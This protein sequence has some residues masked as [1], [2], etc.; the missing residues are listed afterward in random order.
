MDEPHEINDEITAEDCATFRQLLLDKKIFKNLLIECGCPSEDADIEIKKAE[1]LVSIWDLK[2]ETES[3]IDDMRKKFKAELGH[4]NA[5]IKSIFDNNKQLAEKLDTIEN[6]V[7]NSE[8]IFTMI[9]GS[10]RG[11]L[12]RKFF[13]LEKNFQAVCHENN[14]LKKD[15]QYEQQQNYILAMDLECKC[16]E[17]YML[18]NTLDSIISSPIHQEEY[19]SQSN[20]KNHKRKIDPSENIR[21]TEVDSAA[22]INYSPKIFKLDALPKSTKRGSVIEISLPK[23]DQIAKDKIHHSGSNLGVTQSNFSSKK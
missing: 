23:E 5:A 17:N 7:K 8:A 19:Q 2:Y 10:E 3:K 18:K 4:N 20:H 11:S 12:E 16:Q 9:A 21:I 14:I 6:R 1:Y 22:S 13:D 15:I